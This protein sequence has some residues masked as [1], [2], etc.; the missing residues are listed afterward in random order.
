MKSFFPFLH[1]FPNN[2]PYDSLD[3]AKRMEEYIMKNC[4][5][6]CTTDVLNMY[7]HLYINRRPGIED[8][9]KCYRITLKRG[10]RVYWICGGFEWNLE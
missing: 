1:I 9:E 6:R 4:F 5:R 2:E 7:L 10:F 3:D 8:Q